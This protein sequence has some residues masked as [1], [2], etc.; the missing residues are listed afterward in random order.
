MSILLPDAQLGA[1]EV[2]QKPMAVVTSRNLWQHCI[3]KVP[4]FWHPRP[5]QRQ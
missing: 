5:M 3:R 1:E 4:G 2:V